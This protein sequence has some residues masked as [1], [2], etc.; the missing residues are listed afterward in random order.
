MLCASVNSSLTRHKLAK[1]KSWQPAAPY[2]VSRRNLAALD[3][4]RGRTGTALDDVARQT[5]CRLL[6]RDVRIFNQ[7]DG[8]SRAHALLEGSVRIAQSGSDGGQIIVRFFGPGEMFGTMTL[9]TDRR[10]S[11]DADT[12][13]DAIEVSG[14]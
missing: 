5:R 8:R 9:F 4:F 12:L 6:D 11:A 14:S 13:A 7:G 10:Y 3:L 1:L 2:Q